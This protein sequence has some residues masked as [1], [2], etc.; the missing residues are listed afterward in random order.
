VVFAEKLAYMKEV[1]IAGFLPPLTHFWRVWHLL[2]FAPELFF[3]SFFHIPNTR[4]LIC[5]CKLLQ[6]PA[7]KTRRLS[8]R[9]LPVMR[10]L[11]RIYCHRSTHYIVH[12]VGDVIMPMRYE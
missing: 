7:G 1:T 6:I 10:Q 11:P 12:C 3:W 5:P 2:V 4:R 9:G 8:M